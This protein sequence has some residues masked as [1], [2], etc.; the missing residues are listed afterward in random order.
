M[1]LLQHFRR[2]M[3]G[4]SPIVWKVPLEDPAPPQAVAVLSDAERVRAARFVKAEDAARFNAMRT[5]L[6][7]ALARSSGLAPQ[8]IR[9]ALGPAGK[10]FLDPPKIPP[11]EFSVAHARGLGLLALHD[12]PLGIDLEPVDTRG[13]HMEPILALLNEAERE[14]LEGLPEPAR[15]MFLL[16]AWV[17]REAFVKA[18]GVGL[19]GMDLSALSWPGTPDLEPTRLYPPRSLDR[20]E[21]WWVQF[22]NLGPSHVGAL[23][24][25][26]IAPLAHASW[27]DWS[28]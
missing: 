24:T 5:A 13:D 7:F 21:G 6:R 20:A 2:V 11:L 26:G 18:T 12:R 22:L 9:F 10:P 17:L 14:A 25:A 28:T 8:G 3:P 1:A 27:W 16:R 19:G 15:P 23:V 4:S